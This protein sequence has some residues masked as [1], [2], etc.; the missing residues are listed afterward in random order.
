MKL[1]TELNESIKYVTEKT[2][3]G[4]KTMYIEGVFLQSEIKNRNGRVYPKHVLEREVNR[5]NE[6]F[7]SKGRAFGE[8]GHPDGPQ[9]N[10]DR[11][12]HIIETLKQDGSNFIGRAKITD[13]PMG[14][15]A[16]GIIES[17]GQL[18]VSTRGM[19]S[20]KLNREGVNEVQDD[21]HLA[22]A[23]DI[24][25]DPSAPDAFVN[26]IMEGVEWIWENNMLIAQHTKGLVEQAVR[27]R[28]LETKKL[29][30][31]ENFIKSLSKS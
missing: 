25:A 1:I 14:N 8:L 6:Q 10:L 17:G 29:S 19:G 11:I 24:V 18:G 23:A 22:T 21:F 2:E 5:Y 26:G 13:T 30:I 12:S 15:I 9:I 3:S 28:D 16:R 31:F 7:V 27:S 20:L 4:K